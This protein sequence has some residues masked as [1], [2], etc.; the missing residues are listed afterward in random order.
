M[1]ESNE[2]L[3]LL[4]DSEKNI[5]EAVSLALKKI[6]EKGEFEDSFFHEIYNNITHDVWIDFIKSLKKSYINIQEGEYNSYIQ[7]LNYLSEFLQSQSDQI[8]DQISLVEPTYI[9]ELKKLSAISLRRKDTIAREVKLYNFEQ[10]SQ[11]FINNENFDDI[12]FVKE[13]FN[14]LNTYF[15]SFYS[16]IDLHAIS[17]YADSFFYLVNFNDKTF[18]EYFENINPYLQTN[19]L[20]EK[21]VFFSSQKLDVKNFYTNNGLKNLEKHIVK[22]NNLLLSI[23][24]LI[25][26]KKEESYS[27]EILEIISL[28]T[29]SCKKIIE[30]N[31]DIEDLE[32]NSEKTSVINNLEESEKDYSCSELVKNIRKLFDIFDSND[33]LKN[34]YNSIKEILDLFSREMLTVNQ[35]I[36]KSIRAFHNIDDYENQCYQALYEN[37]NENENAENNI[38]TESNEEAKE[39]EPSYNFNERSVIVNDSNFLATTFQRTELTPLSI[40]EE[41]LLEAKKKNQELQLEL[42]KEKET[43]KENLEGYKRRLKPKLEDMK[44]KLERDKSEAEEKF[45]QEE[46][47]SNSLEADLTREKEQNKKLLEQLE[48]ERADAEEKLNAE[49]ETKVQLQNDLNKSNQTLE[50]QNVASEQLLQQVAKIASSKIQ[51]LE[52]QLEEEK[53]KAEHEKE[54]QG[55]TQKEYEEKSFEFYLVANRELQDKEKSLNEQIQGLEKSLSEKQESENQKKEENERLKKEAERLEKEL[56]SR[57]LEVEKE[58]REVQDKKESKEKAIILN[59]DKNPL[60]INQII[61]ELE[62]LNRFT[63]NLYEDFKNI[64]Q[65]IQINIQ[66]ANTLLSE[67]TSELNN[68]ISIFEKGI[69]E[70]KDLIELEQLEKEFYQKFDFAMQELSGYR[71]LLDARLNQYT[72]LEKIIRDAN[73]NKADAN[74]RSKRIENISDNS[75]ERDYAKNLFTNIS[76]LSQRMTSSNADPEIAK[77][78]TEFGDMQNKFYKKL[79]S[80]HFAAK[81][82][83]EAR[84]TIETQTDDDITFFREEENQERDF[85]EQEPPI[86][87]HNNRKTVGTLNGSSFVCTSSKSEPDKLNIDTVN[88]QYKTKL[89]DTLEYFLTTVTNSYDGNKF[90]NINYTGSMDMQCLL[91]VFSNLFNN[92]LNLKHKIKCKFSNLKFDDDGNLKGVEAKKLVSNYMAQLKFKFKAVNDKELAK[93]IS[94]VYLK[95]S[96]WGEKSDKVKGILKNIAPKDKTNYIISERSLYETIYSSQEGCPE[97]LR[98]KISEVGHILLGSDA[99][100]V[101]RMKARF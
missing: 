7:K 74:F 6:V 40:L 18:L 2:I 12:A 14:Y 65:K 66:E 100:P 96:N 98:N 28:I 97:K 101:H 83:R 49:I 91:Y 77:L 34:E 20:D 5:D 16:Y 60:L 89:T 31:Y 68:L 26:Q 94:E 92:H 9:E 8:E 21:L 33:I 1:G 55:K 17:T 25:E 39:H 23:K 78:F 93:N 35:V 4:K 69:Y 72:D 99:A 36:L 15:K 30:L 45:R 24:N 88:I 44:N 43:S 54:L 27:D 48:K 47:K 57:V 29:N 3:E 42:Q 41:Q 79:D 75:E 10:Q 13:Q 71:K 32:I 80:L 11:L 37:E 73:Q 56:D 19:R 76:E 86:L 62:E 95:A 63:G 61:K 90:R 50:E 67:G 52:K 70:A 22:L 59:Y 85:V 84:K 38:E 82:K 53:L 87:F 51:E 46:E 64:N 81:N 58:L